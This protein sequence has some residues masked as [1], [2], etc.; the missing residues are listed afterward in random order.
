M[1]GG[2][3]YLN[4]TLFNHTIDRVFEGMESCKPFYYYFY[5][6]P[7]E[8]LPWIF[9][10]PAAIAYGYSREAVR[11]K[12]GVSF[13][14]HMVRCDLSLFLSFEGEKGTLSFASLPSGILMIGK[15]WDDFLSARWSHFRREWISF[16]LY[17]LMGIGSPRRCGHSLGR[18]DEVSFLSPYSLPMAFL[19]VGGGLAMFVLYRFKNHGSHFLSSHR[20]HGRWILLYIKGCFSTGQS[21]QIGPFHFPRDYVTDSTWGE[22]GPLRRIWDRALQFLYWDCSYS[23]D[24]GER[25]FLQFSYDPRKE[26]SASLSLRDFSSFQAAGREA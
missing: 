16:P 15:L 18:F 24:G 2:K 13:S 5:N 21:I 12:E 11:E 8:F 1:Q 19:M 14:S 7:V 22:T 25:G 20:D 9:F 17:G 6:F 10:L 4:D 23:G 26:Y 3:D